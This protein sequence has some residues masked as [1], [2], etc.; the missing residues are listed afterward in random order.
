MNWEAIGAIGELLS[1]VVVI[2]SIFYLARQVRQG[3]EQTRL[4]AIQAINVSNDSAFDPIYIPENSRIWT[5]CHA[6]APDVDEHEL[7]IFDMLMARLIGSFDTTTYQ[8]EHGAFDEEM[9]LG[10]LPFFASFVTTPG[11]AEWLEHRRNVFMKS[12]MEHLD[13]AIAESRIIPAREW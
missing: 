5:R 1:A 10:A 4:N 6:K 7:Q 3:T 13:R 9:Y 2:F 8:Y 12:T 11:G